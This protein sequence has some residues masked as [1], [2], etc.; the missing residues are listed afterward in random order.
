MHE[1][2]VMEKLQ[3]TQTTVFIRYLDGTHC[4]YLV[5]GELSEH[6]WYWFR[7]YA[8]YQWQSIWM[9]SFWA[10]VNMY[11]PTKM[12][13]RMIAADKIPLTAMITYFLVFRGLDAAACDITYN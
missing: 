12:A 10:S 13:A 3:L 11:M 4:A 1:W 5:T 9:I 8:V 7:H 2:I 6:D